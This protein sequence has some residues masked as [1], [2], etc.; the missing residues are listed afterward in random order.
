M[1]IAAVT[2]QLSSVARGATGVSR[3]GKPRDEETLGA[4]GILGV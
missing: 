4:R 3:R 2:S 1:S